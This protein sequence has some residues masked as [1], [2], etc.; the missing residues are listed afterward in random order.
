MDQRL[1][2]PLTSLPRET[3]Y[4]NNRS[5]TSQP[6]V[7][8]LCIILPVICDDL[9]QSAH[10]PWPLV[11]QHLSTDQYWSKY[12]PGAEACAVGRSKTITTFKI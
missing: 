10:H 7:P 11:T 6:F 8:Q 1:E 3:I 9:P 2:S 4:Q 12:P 5:P